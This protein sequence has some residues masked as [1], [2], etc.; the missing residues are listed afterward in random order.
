MFNASISEN[1]W[2]L[3]IDL[4]PSMF[5]YLFIISRNYFVDSLALLHRHAVLC[6]SLFTHVWL[7]VTP[8]TV[9]LQAPLSIGILRQ[10]YWSGLPCT[11]PENLPDPGIE[12][13]SSVLQADLYHQGSWRILEWVA[14]SFYRGLPDP[15]IELG[16][17]D[18]CIA[19][20]FFTSWATRETP[21]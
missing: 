13:E 21:T 8:R 2:V 6:A 10:E 19:G 4:Y 11:P 14:Y 18:S 17:F 1:I 3:F 7:F 9:T 16:K 20:G 15:G 5:L 12:P